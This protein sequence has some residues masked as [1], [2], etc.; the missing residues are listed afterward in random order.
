M[1][2][3]NVPGTYA[4]IS[5]AVAASVSGD[6]IVV[7]ASYAANESVVVTVDNLTF[8]VAPSLAGISLT[9]GAGVT[10]ITLSG[11]AS[12]PINGNNA[13]NTLNGG[14]GTD[15]LY[16]NGGND[17]LH[18]ND[19][20]DQLVGG[21]GNDQIDGG[22]GFDTVRY[23]AATAGVVVNL[24]AGTGTDGQ[25]GSDALS[26]VEGV[27]GT[28]FA[29][30]I[31]LA[32]TSGWVT[33][34]AG[35]DKLTGGTGDD[36]M[37]GGSGTDTI[38]GGTGID[39]VSYYDDGFDTAGA[40]V[41]GVNVNLQTGKAIDNWGNTD[42]LSGIEN[43][44][45][46]VL[47][48]TIMGDG[49]NNSFTGDKGDDTLK[50]GDGNDW[51]FG[52]AGNDTIDGGAGW[53]STTYQGS[54]SGVLVNLTTGVASDGL[55]STDTLTGIESVDGSAY[56][57]SLT[58][59]DNGN[60]LYGDSGNDTLS[61]LGGND[62]VNGGNGNDTLNGGDG[63]D[64]SMGGTGDDVI[65]GGAGIDTV[66]Y[67]STTAGVI[68]NLLTGKASDGQGGTDSLAGIENVFGSTFADTVTGNANNNALTGDQ[69]NDTLKGGDG[70]DWLDGGSGADTIDGGTGWDTATYQNATGSVTASLQTGAAADGSGGTDT[71][72]GI[73]SLL[74]SAFG[75]SLSGDANGNALTGNGGNDT[76]SGGAGV[77]SLYGGDGNDTLSGGDDGDWLDGGAGNDQIDGGAGWDTATYQNATAGVVANLQ[78]GSASD[79]V[80]GTDTLT[81]IEG[82]GGSA[83]DDTLTGDDNGNT[84]N[85]T[86]GDDT[87]GGL[88][89]N[90]TLVGADGNDTLEGGNDNDWLD[91]GAGNDQLDGGA[92]WDSA[93][94]QSATAGVVA[95]LQTGTA[96]D[97]LGGTDSLTGIESLFGSAFS[98]SFTGDANGNSLN[99]NG[100]NDTLSG[101]A[102]YDSLYGGDGNDTL[103]GGD[104]NDWLSGG[105]GDD[106]VDGG[107]GFDSV[108]YQ[109]STAGVAVN[110]LTGAA[111]DGMGG[112]DSLT[113]IEQVYGSRFADTITLSNVNS[114]AWGR[115]G[116]DKITGGTANDTIYGGSGAD[117]IN[118][119]AGTD[120]ANYYDD[121]QDTA[122]VGTKGVTANLLTGKA[123]DNWGNADTLTGIENLY[124][125]ALVD[126]FTGDNNRNVLTG[127]AGNDKLTG[128]GGN[129]DL[130]G[131]DGNDVVIGGDGIDYM[132]GSAGNDTFDGGVGYDF[133]WW[134]HAQDFDTVDY[135]Y[136]TTTGV[137]VDLAAGTASDGQGGTDT[138]KNIEQVFGTAFN[139]TLK[140]GGDPRF[141][142][143]RGGAG[144]DT[145]I[146][147]GKANT[148]ADY[149]DSTDGVTIT[150]TG[151]AD[152]LGSV[153]GGS[154]GNDTTRY[155]NQFFGSAYAD[156]YDAS[157][158]VLSM[159][160][161]SF[162]FN[163]FRGGAGND[164]IIG[165]G[166]TRLDFGNSTSGITIDLGETTVGD[167]LGGIDTF[168]GANSVTG[169]A[170][171]DVMHGTDKGET[172]QG[173]GGDDV[174]D[175]GAGF[176]EVRYD[177]GTN[178]YS[179]GITVDMKAGT[180]TGD[181]TY[182]GTDTLV[183]IEGVR[184]SLFDD[185]YV[186]T[187]FKSGGNTGTFRDGPL[188]NPNYNRFAGLSGKDKITGNG[189]TVLDYRGASAAITV[190]FTGQGKG[191]ANGTT[192]GID[193]FTGVYA[194]N[195]SAFD[196][197]LTGSNAVAAGYWEGFSLSGGNDT[198][199]GGAGNDFISY[200]ASTNAAINLKF[201]GVGEGQATGNGTD[202]FFGIEYVIGSTENDKMTG[203]DGNQTFV[204]IG[205]NDQMNGGAGTG[206][207]VSYF[208]D[209]D[210]V[211]V[212]LTTGKAQD[213]FGGTDTLAGFEIVV[214]SLFDDRLTGNASANTLNGLSGNDTLDGKAG[215]DTMNGG[216]GDDSYVVDNAGDKAVE[217]AAQGIDLVTSSVS[218]TLGAN[219]E[220][221]TLSGTA[222]VNGTGNT[223]AN[224]LIG[225]SGANKL[226]GK[227]GADT[228][229]GGAG[230]DSYVVDN[231]G[232]QVIEDLNKGTDL[233]TSSVSFTLGDNIEKL[234]LAGTS[235]LAGT[236][237][238]LANTI[239][240][241]AG[242]NVL[243]GKVGNDTLTGG[244]GTDTYAFTTA[245]N[246]LSNVDT[247]VGFVSGSDRIS[248]S[249]SVFSAL[250]AGT[251]SSAAFVQGVAATTSSQHIIYNATT[252]VVSYDAD[253][254]GAGAAV[255]FAKVTPGQALVAGDFKIV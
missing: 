138:L 229:R 11:G 210:G 97:G 224:V 189:Q 218:F 121:G 25:S 76:L 57:D 89:S 244:A 38:K 145:I 220:N 167:G 146:G 154:T 152:G 72:S 56:V 23:D 99:G 18:G 46:S 92:G 118:G 240:G 242:N 160:S 53:D 4:T 162:G 151:A 234:T 188:V 165:N 144:D 175:G 13:A 58:G 44:A 14:T 109:D 74:G 112:T 139:D 3:R 136:G 228:M 130:Y 116:N 187:G 204:G 10:T 142:G 230:N 243:D 170:Y 54:T 21:A 59:D 85:G 63:D 49:N 60:N 137:V 158:Y 233:V 19:G 149:G 245:L 98:D 77:D 101:G 75:D 239:V 29:D 249:K 181:A 206:D 161:A 73:E 111:T 70:N 208:F 248:L 227:T 232:D 252:G 143:F 253:G 30:T 88:G 150:L 45:G 163:V 168:S 182:V 132:Q 65:D 55:G 135:R 105:A 247:L 241:N 15:Y 133:S 172:F 51:L 131:G 211:T 196:D 114:T 66:A 107:A 202:T 79:G 12:V 106:T 20:N 219:V 17:V 94:Y 2:I 250:S 9:A 96:A 39:T 190:T 237:N 157:A 174:I 52:G 176:D 217:A 186:A 213:S 62:T 84:L 231:A 214:G 236:G 83:F 212:N 104:D 35:N 48:D 81:G 6:T 223:L 7:A 153:T 178:A 42:T 37:I 183:N 177:G 126:T 191:T 209:V 119:G 194:I 198:V 31:T 185:T 50:G 102:G 71:L 166:N 246:A 164:T 117:T 26:G 95:N 34:R 184:G 27:S 226:D 86:G 169:T 124:G 203:G 195:D 255:A 207:T 93:T 134:V 140:G 127:N 122:G 100:G 61:A 64:W 215:A 120:A 254:N 67:G 113:N 16:G 90:D 1:T 171:A 22:A 159:P 180:V 125:S 87:L 197:T 115:A 193:T 141:Q 32:N 33:G 222:A 80:G 216:A 47:A 225:N 78:T 91:G 201:T 36:N 205:G 110:L 155:V 235:A 5:A 8:N 221:L 251:L 69:G 192:E 199:K 103:S 41:Q 200:S 156:T 148:R 129:D 40:G 108:T 28:R 173:Q 68:V 238:A 82:L 24:Q 128:G 179:V 147:S 43:V 123:T